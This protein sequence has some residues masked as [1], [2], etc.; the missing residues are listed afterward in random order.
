MTKFIIF[1]FTVLITSLPIAAIA[2]NNNVPSNQESTQMTEEEIDLVLETVCEAPDAIKNSDL[3]KLVEREAKENSISNSRT[4]F[5]EQ[6]AVDIKN[7]PDNE[8]QTLC[9]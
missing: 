1:S 3:I 7:L 9:Q 4:N 8:E 6:V 2:N 5:L